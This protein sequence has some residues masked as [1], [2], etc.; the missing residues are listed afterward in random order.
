MCHRVLRSLLSRCHNIAI[1]AVC[2][3]TRHQCIITTNIADPGRRPPAAL[4]H[5][6]LGCDY[7]AAV[8][9]LSE[10]WRKRRSGT[11]LRIMD[12]IWQVAI[13]FLCFYLYGFYE[14]RR[15]WVG[16]TL[17]HSFSKHIWLPSGAQIQ[18]HYELKVDSGLSHFHTHD[19]ISSLKDCD[20]TNFLD[21]E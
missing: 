3:T 5:H 8:P 6:G 11:R 21:G 4:H 20:G 9:F 2:H 12:I 1:A 13:L 16:I 19:A 17:Q 10:W 15:V 18:S 7:P 14:T